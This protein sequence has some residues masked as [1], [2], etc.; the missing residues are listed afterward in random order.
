[1]LTKNSY[2]LAVHPFKTLNSLSREK[3]R[4]QELLLLGLPFLV[5]V[6]GTGVVW[7]GRRLLAT[8]EVW[9]WGA[10]GTAGIFIALSVALLIYLGFWWRKVW[11]KR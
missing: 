6:I 10:R 5:L 3:D 11:L 9:G 8:T 7:T 4:S 2:G 1:L